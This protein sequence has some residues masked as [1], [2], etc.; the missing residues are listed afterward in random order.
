MWR[1][2]KGAT[3]RSSTTVAKSRL[4][5][6]NGEKSTKGCSA[7]LNERNRLIST[8]NCPLECR[9]RPLEHGVKRSGPKAEHRQ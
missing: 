6:L 2:Q 3:S 1:D 8:V 7:V 5:S 4:H 9:P